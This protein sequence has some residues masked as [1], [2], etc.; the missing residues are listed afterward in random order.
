MIIVYPKKSSTRSVRGLKA[1]SSELRPKDFLS[2]AVPIAAISPLEWFE[3][4]K[5]NF[6]KVCQCINFTTLFVQQTRY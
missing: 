2:T 1:F 4:E 5:L 3:I 6:S